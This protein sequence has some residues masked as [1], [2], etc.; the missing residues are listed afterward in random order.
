METFLTF[1]ISN[2]NGTGINLRFI[3]S[4]KHLA[5]ALDSLVNYLFNRDT[6]I[7][8]IKTKFSS[9]FQHFK[10]DA[11]KLLREGGFPHDYMDED[12]EKK[13]KEK[14]LRD[15]KYFHSIL[16]NTECSDDDYNYAR[17]TFN[18]FG[19][20]EITDYIDLYVKTDVLLL[21]NVFIAYRKEMYKIY[22]SDPLYCISVPGFSNRAMLKMTNVEIKLITN[23]DM[24][25]MIENGIRGG[26][27]EP[28]Y[29]YPKANNK[30]INPNFNNEKE[31]CIISLD[32]NSLYA[33]AIC[34][35]LQHGEIK[36]DHNISKH[37][38]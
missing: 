33:S 36:I 31:S 27:R 8:S 5:Y 12:C 9:L 1:S 2:F 32:V 14:K 18:Y 26:R 28:I 7:Q 24:H 15:I 23:I 30:Y 4:Y 38:N 37:T 22:G 6:N 20:K 29:Y 16:N 11:M 13:L 21:A 19:C 10:D 17:E 34:Y 3:D 25:L 35:E